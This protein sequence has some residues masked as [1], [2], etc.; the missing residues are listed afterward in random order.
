MRL[1]L[2]TSVSNASESAPA[3]PA[4]GSPSRG[5][6]RVGDSSGSRDS[7]SVSGASAALNALSSQRGSR[8]QQL[9]AAV[10]SGQYGVS[11]AALSSAIVSH[12]TR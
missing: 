7:I 8:I 5:G 2:N 3:A 11:S 4:N 9:S 12:A 10:Q 1:Q 6:T